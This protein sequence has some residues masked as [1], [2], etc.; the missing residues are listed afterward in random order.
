MKKV[1][2]AYL[3]YQGGLANVF[4]V[5]TLRFNH[6]ERRAVRLMQGSFLEC[7]CFCG[8]L[9][10]A[11]VKVRSAQCNYAGDITQIAWSTDLSV[12][13]FADKIRDVVYN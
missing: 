3:V 8:G 4:A 7:V 2:N 9:G 1:K 13:P 10:A 5:E 12:A 11:G 6:P